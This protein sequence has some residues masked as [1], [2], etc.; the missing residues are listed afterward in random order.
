M[1]IKNRLSLYFTALSAFVLL[2]VQ[3]VICVTFNSL[4]KSDF[5]DHLLDRAHVA[6]QLYLEA[7]EISADSLNHVRERYF[8]QLPAE[9]VRFY[10]DK[11]SASF[12]KDKDQ[13]W[14]GPVID[15][16]RK[17]KQME[18]SQG[19][20]Q[21]VGIYYNDNQGNF[22]ILVSAIDFPGSKRFR[23]LV[24]SMAILLVSVTAGLFVTSRWFAQKA[25]EPMDSVIKQMRRVRAGNLSLRV[26]EG[27]GK[28]EISALAHNFN[29]LLEHLENAFE[30]QQ[31]FIIN[32][33]HELRTP[34]TTIIG[35]VEI[36]LNKSRTGAE[37]NHVLNSVLSDAERLNETIN[38]LLELANVDMNYTQPAHLPVA[39]DELIWELKDYWS[40]KFGKGMFNVEVKELPENPE[41]LQIF[42]NKS[43]LTIAFNNVI[44]NAF[45]FSQNKQVTCT[46][47]ADSTRIKLTFKDLGIGILPGELEKI[48]ESFY[49]GTNVKEFRGN[50][51]GLYVTNKIIRLFN[52]SI[53]AKSSPGNGTTV[54][55]EFRK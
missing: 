2:V 22:V 8:Q 13:F 52:G 7:D 46:L 40:D 17:R 55:I 54:I 9:V 32:A 53:L 21:S 27:N 19:H 35:E 25:L 10:N 41:Q 31:T 11:N 49:R 5:Y 44:G 4:V 33:S 38:S 42:A 20:R 47:H 34:I 1:K 14:S 37:Y 30:L 26:D 51:V 43:L 28:D 39:I 16:V 48:F 6:A 18:F 3:V 50:G 24:E 23:D 45:K 12:I 36:A 15:A 29:Q